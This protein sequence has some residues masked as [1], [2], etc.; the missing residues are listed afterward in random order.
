MNRRTFIASV[1]G[2]SILPAMP[3]RAEAPAPAEA[4]DLPRRSTSNQAPRKVIVGAAMQS[5][6]GEYPG[7]RSRL[8]QLASMVDEMAAQAHAQFGRGLDLAILPEAAITGEV[9]DNGLD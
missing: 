5:F 3:S 4:R 8:E 6:W 7:L 2:L 1:G 9:G